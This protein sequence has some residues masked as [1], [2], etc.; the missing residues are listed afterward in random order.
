MK[1]IKR[2]MCMLLVL[3]TCLGV[4]TPAASAAVVKK[5]SSGTLV[6]QVQYNLNA[7]GFNVGSVDGI[8]GNNTVNGIKNYQ[9]SR[10]LDV[11]GMAGPATQNKL[12]AE[13]KDIQTRLKRIGCYS[14]SVDGIAGPNT[15]SGIKKFQKLAGLKQT[16]VADSTTV[17]KLKGWPVDKIDTSK[18]QITSANG[19]SPAKALAF[20]KQ[21]AK[22]NTHWLCA[23]YVTRCL[24]AGGANV[25][26]KKFADEV[27]TEMEKLSGVKRYQLTVE[28]GGHVLPKKNQ[29]KLSSGDV[30]AIY[31]KNC[32]GSPWGHVVMV[33][34]LDSNGI[35]VYAHNRSYNNE[36]YYGFNS[37]GYCSDEG[38]ND[39]IAYV[40]HFT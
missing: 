8:A 21:N 12:W 22:T 1:K 24:A 40:L 23:E 20:A 29:G 26:I 11:D 27:V 39:V 9:K 10:G 7:L 3:V 14:D 37:C 31:C 33:G 4:L 19:Y 13:I 16:G 5:G 32:S 17:K 36:R 28:P 18:N 30:I 35:R 25:R 15:I 38:P 34:D 2:I 6:R